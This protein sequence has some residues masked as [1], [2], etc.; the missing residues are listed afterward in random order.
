MI[1]V[2]RRRIL[3]KRLWRRRRLSPEAAGQ[4][5]SSFKVLLK[6]L[7]CDQLDDLLKVVENQLEDRCVLLEGQHR[8]RSRTDQSVEDSGRGHVLSCRL[9]RWPMLATEECRLWP[10]PGC[11][12]SVGSESRICLNPYHW[13]ININGQFSS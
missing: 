1:E 2:L 10:T 11:A 6:G 3:T 7:S 13:A 12:T 9:W 4:L 5:R 8:P